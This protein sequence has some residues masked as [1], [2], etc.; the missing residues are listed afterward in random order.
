[1]VVWGMFA[2]FAGALLQHTLPAEAASWNARARLVCMCAYRAVKLCEAA[3]CRAGLHHV[4][5]YSQCG[6]VPN[7]STARAHVPIMHDVAS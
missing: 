2:R 1:M 4:L 7:P 3:H 6:C 5:L